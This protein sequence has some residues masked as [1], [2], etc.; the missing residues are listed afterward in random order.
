LGNGRESRTPLTTEPV[1][2]EISDSNGKAFNLAVF[3]KPDAVPGLQTGFSVYH[4]VLVP[5]N[6]PKVGEIILAAHAVLIRPKYEWLN[7]VLV[8]RHSV[9]G[10]PFVFHTPGFYSQ[11]SEQFHAYRPYFRYQYV[12]APA[13]EPIFPDVGLRSGPSVG[14][15]YDAS[16]F[17]ALKLQYDHTTLRRQPGVDSITAQ[18]GFTF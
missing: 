10:T 12:N 7:E 6:Q 3:A 15:R 4:S 18:V 11:V 1:Q 13:N 2:N 8:D 17:V 5:Q 14:L 9:A 16:E